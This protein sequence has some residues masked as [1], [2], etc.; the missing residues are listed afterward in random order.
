MLLVLHA[1]QIILNYKL[2]VMKSLINLFFISIILGSNSLRA[3]DT[4][5][6]FVHIEFN[7]IQGF[8]NIIGFKLQNMDTMGNSNW[9]SPL[10]TTY[11]NFDRWSY[12]LKVNVPTSVLR[13][14]KETWCTA[15]AREN[16]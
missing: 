9:L 11:E 2:R 12:L 16:P 13:N 1:P 14:T 3:Q 15:F 7:G 4:I 10:I 8:S 5:T 6:N